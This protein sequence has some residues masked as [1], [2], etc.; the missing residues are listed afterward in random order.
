MDLRIAMAPVGKMDPAEVEAVATRLAKI[1]NT[2]VALRAP[3]AVPKAGDDPKRGQHL[4]G[5][6]LSDLRLQLPRLAPIKQVGSAPA[7]EPPAPGPSS[8]T[9]V[10]F[11]TDVDLYKPQTDGVFGD[12]DGA[13]HVA[14]LS[15]RRLREAFYKR[16]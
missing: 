2:P 4:A 13:A 11:I 14:V 7:A 1:L 16:K 12:I 3:A 8:T 5:P 6:F 10:I 15:V 9:A